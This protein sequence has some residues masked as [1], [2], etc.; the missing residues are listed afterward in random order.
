VDGTCT[1]IP[2]CNGKECGDNGCS[3]SCGD[4]GPESTCSN[5]GICEEDEVTVTCPPEGPFGT[6]VNTVMQDLTLTDCDGDPYALHALCT[7]DA[8]LL[9]MYADW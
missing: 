7:Q 4:C 5:A 3:G 6:T 9:V 2:D 1:C 8:A